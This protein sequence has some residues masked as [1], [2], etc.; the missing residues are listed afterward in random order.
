MPHIRITAQQGT[1]NTANQDNFVKEI[2]NAVLIAENADPKDPAALSLAWVYFNERAKDS[3]YIGNEHLDTAPI[4]IQ[5]T[6]PA[7]SLDQASR[8]KLEVNINSI[9]NDY[10]G[11]YENRL[12]HWLLMDEIEEGG[13]ASAGIIFSISD[14]KSAMNISQ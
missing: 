1:F 8:N 7:G 13:W 9:I 5:V 10:I 14:V 11:N 6:T 2:T 3:V 4:V 12:N